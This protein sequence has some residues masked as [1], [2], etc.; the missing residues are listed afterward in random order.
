MSSMRKAGGM[1]RIVVAAAL[2][3]LSGPSVAEACSSVYRGHEL[4]AAEQQ[5]DRQPPAAAQVPAD[6]VR[7]LR[8]GIRSDSSCANMGLVQIAFKGAKDD[9][10]P[11]ERIGYRIKHVA[12]TL[13]DGL[14]LPSYAQFATPEAGDVSGE[15]FLLSLVWGD[16]ATSDQGAIDFT[17]AL[18]AVDL[19]GNESA[20]SS[21]I[22][23]RHPGGK[24]DR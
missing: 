19:A 18:T 21:P 17:I 15:V 5:I 14:S 13:P 10:T 1:W 9:R 2:A 8:R 3:C 12:G 22:R 4:D 24:P 23:I 6:V 11:R 16:P 7:V 20:P